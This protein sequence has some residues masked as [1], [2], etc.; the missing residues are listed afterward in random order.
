[1]KSKIV[2]LDI[3]SDVD[4]LIKDADIIQL[5]PGI[6]NFK[7]S[8]ILKKNY[9]TE[10]KFLDYK[11]KLNRIL[12]KYSKFIKDKSKDIDPNLLEFF[13]LRNDKNKF[14]DKIFYILE[15][16]KKFKNYKAVEI[17]TDDQNFVATYKS[18][19]HKNI[20]INFLKKKSI[21][22]GSFY[23]ISKISNFFLKRVFFQIYIKLFLKN[24][25]HIN[26]T[27]E[28]CFSMFPL[29]FNN[30]K[31]TF[32]KENFLNLNFQITDETHLN[33]SLKENMR[34]AKKINR[35][36]NTISV[37]NY[38][39]AFSLLI[40]FLVSLSHISLIK[41]INEKKTKIDNLDVSRQFNN[42]LVQSII[43]YDKV[44]IYKNALRKIFNKFK[45]KKFHYLLF[46]YNFGYF[47]CK[48]IQEFIPKVEMIGYQH[49]IY[50]ER[51]MWQ[52]FLKNKKEKYKY[53]PQQI[54]LKFVDCY[55]VYKDNFKEIYI[56]KNKLKKY[57][58]NIKSK[59]KKNKSNLVFLGLHD[60]F[61]ML[62]FLR[63]SNFNNK[64]F[65]KKHPKF[66][67]KIEFLLK[68][69]IEFIKKIN[70]KYK[71]VYLSP[72]STMTYHYLREKESF[73]IINSN[74]SIPLNLKISDK[75]ISKF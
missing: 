69:N 40:G 58:K 24:K 48:N 74:Y 71:K 5:S 6:C 37:E 63:N 19:K 28:A 59:L 53:F 15:L 67:S 33:N 12:I 45:I 65:V 43:N 17:I 30:N 16:K 49:G 68:K 29:F 27:K 3:S 18:L 44:F 50:S 35:L 2:L 32:Y 36:K 38:V 73:S 52:E 11:E 42:L 60:T 54:F 23:F 41:K 72:S 46:E 26:R 61:Q 39:N 51:L 10:K 31:N 8:S 55:D 75:L 4:I 21:N 22:Y 20:K 57:K 14:Y 47:L 56:S 64:I 34:L 9:F 13:N 70:K 62:N 7:H 66:K 1:M 25:N